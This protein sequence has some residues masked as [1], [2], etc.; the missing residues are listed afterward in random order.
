MAAGGGA[1]ESGLAIL[2]YKYAWIPFIGFLGK[3]L[4][5]NNKIREH[6]DRADSLEGRIT[7]TEADIHNL[8]IEVVDKEEV[9]HII[10]EVMTPYF[11]DQKEVKADIKTIAEN[12]VQLRIE[13]AAHNVSRDR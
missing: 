3:I 11:E 4:W 1:G 6:K 7:Q 13:T 12:V 9:R 5:D 8:Q 2:L 10:K